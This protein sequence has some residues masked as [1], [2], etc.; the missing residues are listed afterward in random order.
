[1]YLTSATVAGALQNFIDHVD[2]SAAANGESFGRWP[3]G[4]GKLYPMSMRTLGGANSGPRIGPVVISEIMYN[5]P[6]G[7]D[8]LEFVELTN[9][10]DQAISLSGWKFDEGINFTFGNVTIQPR[11]TLVVVRFEPANLANAAL[12]TNFRTVYG[13][14]AAVPLIGGYGNVTGGGVLDNG[15][16][17]IRL[18]RPDM[19]Q[20]GGFVPYLLVD[21]VDF[22]DVAP[23]PTPPDGMGPSLTR[24]STVVY[25]HEPTNW[26]GAAPSPGTAVITPQVET[27]TGTNGPDTYY[28]TR[29]GSQLHIYQNAPPVG[30]PTYSIE[31]AA[32]NGTLTINTLDGDDTVIVNTGPGGPALGLAQLI[33]N[34]GTGANGLV[35]ENGSARVDSIVPAGGTLNTTVAAG[36][37]LTTNRLKQNGLTLGANGSV[38]LLPGGTQA[39]VL[40]TLDLGTTGTLDLAD[41]DLVLKTTA[42]AKTAAFN[43]LY[44]RLVAGFAAGAWNG[45]GLV[46]TSA[47]SN[48]NTTLS[49]VDNATL[50]YSSFGGEPVDANSLL[51]KYTYYADIDQNGQVDADDLT[52]FANNFGRING[53]TQVDGDIDFNGRVDADDLTVFANNFL[54][55]VGMPLAVVSG[56]EVSG[57][58]S[59]SPDDE[60]LIDL[61]ARAI[62]GDTIA[63]TGDSLSDSRVATSRRARTAD[64]VWSEAIWSSRG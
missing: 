19:P 22:D 29:S 32:L 30:Q 2:F 56:G 58:S 35:L 42:A 47:Q 15:G 46:S 34:A 12:V 7:N 21:E 13:I 45:N 64:A 31:L 57:E 59:N 24:L 23:W 39:N 55:G 28:V 6:G 10:T 61:L 43:T 40:T 20:P 41:N 36:A 11:S 26:S 53:A 50:G 63:A 38:T 54:R 3:N 25:G 4:A 37:Q 52:V 1:V 14:S 62:A 5:P 51:L 8:D 9:I 27:I 49:L 48:S 60:P 18:A 17:E 44:S 33:Y 16:E